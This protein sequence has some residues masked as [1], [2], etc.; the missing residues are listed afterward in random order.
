MKIKETQ[1][2]PPAGFN[3]VQR[4]IC[5]VIEVEEAPPGATIVPDETPLHDWQD[6][7]A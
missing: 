7:E 1:L 6:E 2:T 4:T 5:R 3:N